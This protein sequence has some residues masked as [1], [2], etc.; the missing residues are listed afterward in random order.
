MMI[1]YIR[2]KAWMWIYAANARAAALGVP[3][4]YRTLT[5]L[6]RLWNLMGSKYRA[7]ALDEMR[8]L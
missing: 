2:Y 5:T 7:R 8:L 4:T 1:N 6:D 3:T